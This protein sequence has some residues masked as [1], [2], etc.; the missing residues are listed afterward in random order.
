MEWKGEHLQHLYESGD[1]QIRN[2]RTAKTK[3]IEAILGQDWKD[4][5]GVGSLA[6]ASKTKLLKEMQKQWEEEN[7]SLFKVCD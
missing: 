7:S 5:L 3:A 4:K 2:I 1:V 6:K